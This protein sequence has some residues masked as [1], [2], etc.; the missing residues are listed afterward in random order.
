MSFFLEC[1]RSWKGFQVV[2]FCLK[3]PGYDGWLVLQCTD[4][5]E[6]HMQR[7]AAFGLDQSLCENIAGL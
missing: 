4:C 5:S 6:S 3:D 7:L 1:V 2:A